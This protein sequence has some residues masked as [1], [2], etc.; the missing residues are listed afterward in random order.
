M[1]R[2]TTKEQLDIMVKSYQEGHTAKEA[3]GRFGYC[4]DVCLRELRRRGIPLRVERMSKDIENK[5]IEAYNTKMSGKAAAAKYGYSDGAF[6]KLLK[7][8][9]LSARPNRKYNLDETFFDEIDMEAKAYWL[10]FITADGNIRKGRLSIN[11]KASDREHLEKFRADIKSEHP[12]REYDQT[13]FGGTYRLARI[14]PS[15][16]HL[17][18]ALRNLGVMECKSLIVKPCKLVPDDLLNHYWRGV[19]DGDGC[20]T[21]SK[22][23]GLNNP[24]YN[25]GL[26]GAKAIIKGFDSYLKES[27][28]ETVANIFPC[29]QVYNIKYGGNNQAK[30]ILKLL[31]EGSTVF[32]T[33]K[34]K[35]ANI[36]FNIPTREEHMKLMTKDEI[37]N[38]YDMIGTWKGV[39][40]SF[41]MTQRGL[42]N[43]RKRVG[44]V[45]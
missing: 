13:V 37:L 29:G 22:R 24:I 9:K 27:G 39:A 34:M 43:V 45:S 19:F 7:R 23:E 21:C 2:K 16:K 40:D 42:L 28:I 14:E 8:R 4:Q 15:S 41:S 38:R 44:L 32:L 35:L 33:R 10:G 25:V 6:F 17:T 3:A 11:L 1:S 26:T 31:Y 36:V 5:I 30:M 12:T 20:I 18:S